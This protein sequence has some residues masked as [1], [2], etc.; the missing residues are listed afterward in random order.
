MIA[1]AIRRFW[2]VWFCAGMYA[3]RERHITTVVQLMIKL[4]KANKPTTL[5]V[6]SIFKS[7]RIW[8]FGS[9]GSP[10]NST[11]CCPHINSFCFFRAEKNSKKT[12]TK[13]GPHCQMPKFCPIWKRY[14]RH[15]QSS[16]IKASKNGSKK[17]N[18][19]KSVCIVFLQYD[20]LGAVEIISVVLVI[21]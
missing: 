8:T 5:P 15:R 2:Y 21:I 20:K 14:L 6:T 4:P 13:I 16:E 10:K 12:D 3:F 18:N 17:E 1:S 11:S 9:A 19:P 7:S